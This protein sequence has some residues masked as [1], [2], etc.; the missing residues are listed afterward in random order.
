HMPDIYLYEDAAWALR[1]FSEKYPLGLLTDGYAQTQRN[2]VT[3]LSIADYFQVIVYSD[4]DGRACWKPS[5]V[6]YQKI[7]TQA[8]A[9]GANCCY[10]ADN[11]SKDFVTARALGWR[12]V[13]LVRKGGEYAD[14]E[15][16]EGHEADH[17]ITS[18]HQLHG[19]LE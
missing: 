19:A 8:E 10:I 2:K 15:A 6:P 4:D 9:A 12:T 18:L 7:M 13:R 11:P 1:Y 14:I 3:A 16:A 17:R 5:H